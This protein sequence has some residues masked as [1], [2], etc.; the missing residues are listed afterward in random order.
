MYIALTKGQQPTFKKFLSGKES[1]PISSE[2]IDDQLK[3]LHLYHCF[4]EAGCTELCNLLEQSQTFSSHTIDLSHIK[5]TT[6]DM[7]CIALFLTT[8]YHKQWEELNLSDCDIQDHGIYVLHS[9][10]KNTCI[11][12]LQLSNN[13]LTKAASFLISDI[14]VTCKVKKLWI[15]GNHSVGEDLQFCSMIT[16][17]SATLEYL[18]MVDTHLS[19][20][21]AS[22]L[23]MALKY[24]N[25]LKELV[26][27]DNYVTDDTCD[28]ITAALE[29]NK[30][31]IKLWMWNNP[32]CSEALMSILKSLELNNTLALLGL[33]NCPEIT[34]RKLASLQEVVNKKRE[35]HGCQVKLVI[36]FM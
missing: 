8:S 32:I 2:F 23:F 22:S 4:Y 34:K 12:T 27:A 3:C 31:L 6:A 36:D 9:I 30:S 14:V 1:D 10:L 21:G 20:R 15:A 11:T 7:K 29:K 17:S 5:L 33:P 16:N 24:N 26:I 35:S 19:S 18:H 13:C 28:V 25:T